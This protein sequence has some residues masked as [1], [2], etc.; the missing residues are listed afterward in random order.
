MDSTPFQIINAAAGSG[1]TFAL[2]YAYL[3]RLLSADRED[4]YKKMLALTFTNKAV[5]EMKHRILNN[6]YLLGYD[7]ENEKIK[8]IRSGLI[9]D[10]KTSEAYLQE[11]AKRRLNKI[12]H[13]Y[14][15]FEVITLDSFTHKII[16]S[17][18]KDLKIP[19][20]FEVTLDSDLLL[21]QMTE[22]ILEQAGIDPSLTQILVA[23][24]L[25]KT[26]ELK[27]WNVSDDLL[28]FSHLLLQEND[29][30]PISNLKNKSLED[31][32]LQQNKFQKQLEILEKK[33]KET[34]AAAL[35]MFADH[36]LT[37]ADFNRKTLY[38]HF[39]KIALAQTERLYDNRLEEN[40][41]TGENIYKKSLPD[42]KKITID[43][44]IPQLYETFIQAKKKVGRLLLLK[45]LLTQWTP[46][47]LIGRMEKGLEALQLPENKLL[48][49]RF[50]EMI[51]QEISGLEAPY[52]Y[53]R[54]GEKYRHY[55]IDEFQDT[56]RLQ[57]KN[58]IP[59][60]SNALQSLDEAQQMG[61]LLLVGDPK[62]AIYRW[63]GGDNEQF[64][65]LLDQKS[66]FQI[67]PEITL[68]PKNHRSR[69][70]IVDFNNH[71]FAWLGSYLEDPQQKLM[72]ERQTQQEFND[73]VG[74]RVGIQFIE[75]AKRKEE[76]VEHHQ[77]QT[78][79]ALRAARSN[80]HSWKD[81]A[82]LVRK[83]DQATL[84]ATALQAEDI[85]FISS[86]SLS[87]GSSPK[88][89][90]LMALLRLSLY[91]HDHLQ[92]K[93]IT[94]FL[95]HQ[96]GRNGNLHEILSRLV[97]L[98]FFSFQ[99]GI[100]EQF[101][102]AFDFDLFSK[103]S[104]YHALEYAIA[105]FGLYNRMEAHLNAFLDDVYEFGMRNDRSFSGYERHWEQKGKDQKIVIPDGTNAVKI[106]TI[107]KA[108]GLEFPVVVL[109]FASEELVP[110]RSQKVWYP[111][112]NHFETSFECGRVHFSKKLKYLGE[113]ASA[114]YE[115][116]V[117]NDRS[118][119][120]NTLYVA[121]TRAVSEMY[122]ICSLEEPSSSVLH[123]QSTLLNHFVRSRNHEPEID[124]P[125]YWGVTQK[126]TV[127]EDSKGV[128]SL[129]P[130]FKVQPRW[131][132]RLWYQLHST[133]DEST[134]AAKKEGLL[135]HDL[136]A[137][138]YHAEDV[139][140]VVTNAYQ[141]G[142]ITQE[143]VA[144]YSHLVKNVVEHPQ[145]KPF[146]REGIKVYNE[147]DILIPQK[148]FIRPDRIVKNDQGWIVIDYK[149]GKQHPNHDRQIKQYAMVLEEM[150]SE[151]SNSFLVYL[152]QMITVKSVA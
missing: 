126:A 16:K 47:M 103:K 76:A 137:A 17:F 56:S 150:T 139:S 35:K 98:P 43:T 146:F 129:Q 32:K 88:V 72:F 106:M 80:G 118:D 38:R 131:E 147:K 28:E 144:H 141:M 78:L 9:I 63:R 151:K 82:I 112:K 95:F 119:A 50:N 104:L 11:K 34:G 65:N 73:K 115:R 2:V 41:S 75:K 140:S 99:K 10:L 40:L 24:S 93:Q 6:L 117:L 108:K 27:S 135:V 25:S 15:A 4:A 128:M 110:T 127:E 111:I 152:G 145:L 86:E 133:F 132:Q 13:E 26:E 18:A 69:K 90:F 33:L 60:I 116:F 29:R 52:I 121:M 113:S 39:E 130:D 49:S 22:N 94:A 71:F 45:S 5:N 67:V 148:S 122:L 89:N 53:E 138:V 92:K 120:L 37:A 54:L 70:A 102:T 20:S 30:E 59:L 66:P 123:S 1:K 87:L 125:F 142:K 12:L 51:D 48:L 143:E 3:R 42:S 14:A 96:N 77:A 81:M 74:G 107:H 149:T 114:F 57:W 105:S 97:F 21:E 136:L 79:V 91:P 44:L 101:N 124:Q 23:F 109:P 68:L 19:A 64:L 58:L 46:M 36:G 55:F 31:F 85:P 83:K 100:N 62:Q 134:I 8:H 84:I 61:T 7:I